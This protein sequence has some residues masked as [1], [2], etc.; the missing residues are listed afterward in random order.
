MVCLKSHLLVTELVCPQMS[1]QSE[2]ISGHMLMH[3]FPKLST[4]YFYNILNTYRK[5]KSKFYFF[6]IL[7][8]V[9]L[10]SELN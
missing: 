7:L 4:S 10:T 6:Q 3:S 2:I 8:L 5:K 1:G 9:V